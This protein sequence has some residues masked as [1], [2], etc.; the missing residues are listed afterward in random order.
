MSDVRENI[1]DEKVVGSQKNELSYNDLSNKM[2]RIEDDDC[3]IKVMDEGP[4]KV[5][6]IL[7]SVAFKKL[8]ARDQ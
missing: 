8:S 7:K 1:A 6:G 4:V 2:V 3:V 5:S